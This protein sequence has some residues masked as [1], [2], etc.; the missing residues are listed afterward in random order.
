MV[1]APAAV[2]ALGAE[3][4]AATLSVCARAVVSVPDP[5][6]LRGNRSMSAVARGVLGAE[7]VCGCEWLCWC[8]GVGE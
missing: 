7:V 5:P 1:V 8:V 4:P 6:D 3:A 2:A